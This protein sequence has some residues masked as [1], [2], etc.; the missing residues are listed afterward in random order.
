[1]NPAQRQLEEF[2]RSLPAKRAAQCRAFVRRLRRTEKLGEI[3][4]RRGMI[5]HNQL[6]EA[7]RIQGRLRSLGRDERIG[8]ILVNRKALT[9]KKLEALLS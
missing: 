2:L 6:G 1:M 5:T 7:L 4:L 9:E 3:A 8:Q